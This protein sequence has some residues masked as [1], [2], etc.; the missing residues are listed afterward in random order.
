MI[1]HH[2]LTSGLAGVAQ[3]STGDTLTAGQA[4]RLACTAGILPVVLGTTSEILDLGRTRRLF[5][6]PLRTALDLRDQHCRATGCDIPAAW[7]E[8]HHQQPWSQQGPTTLDNGILLCPHHHHR[9]H[10]PTYTHT[11]QPTGHLTFHRRT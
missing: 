9:A 3:T 5:T 4:R 10:D 2:T 11:H 1:D 6:G 7:C 8:A